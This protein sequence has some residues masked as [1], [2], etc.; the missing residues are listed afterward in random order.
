VS[1]QGSS[2]VDPKL[3]VQTQTRTPKTYTTWSKTQGLEETYSIYL[4]LTLAQKK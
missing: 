2:L 4:Q 1:P 3:K